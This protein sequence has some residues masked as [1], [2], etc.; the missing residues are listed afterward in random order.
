MQVSINV[1]V[2]Q[3]PGWA[4]IGKDVCEKL[5]LKKLKKIIFIHFLSCT[6]DCRRLPIPSYRFIC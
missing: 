4:V 2:K 1:E 5:L 6:D 3:L